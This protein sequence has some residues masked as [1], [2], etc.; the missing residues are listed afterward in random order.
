MVSHNTHKRMVSCLQGHIG[1]DAEKRH[2]RGKTKTCLSLLEFP[3]CQLFED[4]EHLPHK[5]RLT[6][7]RY[8][9]LQSVICLF[10]SAP[11]PIQKHTLQS[12]PRL[13]TGNGQVKN[14]ES[15]SFHL[16]GSWHRLFH[17]PFSHLLSSLTMHDTLPFGSLLPK[18]GC[19][20]LLYVFPHRCG[21]SR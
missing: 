10:F 21:E 19:S 9:H 7:S 13:Y 2:V 20:N 4:V 18:T 5:F 16:S 11:R 15:S 3:N 6:V 14:T 17:F 1:A 12:V 8:P